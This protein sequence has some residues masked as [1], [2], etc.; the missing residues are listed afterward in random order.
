QG[1]KLTPRHY[2]YLK[3]S[4]GCNH[5]C[6]FCIIPYGRG[7]SRSAPAGD[8]VQQIRKLVDNGY[9][10]V[11]LTGV[12]ITSWGHDLP[13]KPSFGRL[14][15]QVLRHVRDLERLRIS[16]I[17]CIEAD[18]ALLDCIASEKRLM[19]HLH[20]SLQAGDDMILKR[21][22]RRHLRDEAIRFCADIRKLRPDMVFGADIIAGF[23]TETE[24]MFAQSLALVDECDLTFLHV[25]PFSARPGT[26]AARMP[27]QSR[28]VVKERAKR[29]REKGDSALRAHLRRQ[30]GRTLQV[31]AESKGLSRAEDFTLVRCGDH[32]PGSVVQVQVQGDNGGEL[33]AAPVGGHS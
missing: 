18:E 10:E 16:S 33:L 3:I 19:P 11:V 24:A 12:D 8:V 15:Q 2:A 13:G 1:V 17:D 31:L 25:F 14:V 5:R 21:M 23:P 27:M 32:K 9:R 7:P 4:E 26:P 30:H 29:L 28:E 6:T 22:K 20:L